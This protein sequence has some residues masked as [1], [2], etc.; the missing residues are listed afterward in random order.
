MITI[1]LPNVNSIDAETYKKITDNLNLNS[2]TYS[3]CLKHTFVRHGYYVRTLKFRN[4]SVKLRILRV[5]CFFCETTHAI[6][7]YF[8]VPYS[9]HSLEIHLKAILFRHIDDFLEWIEWNLSLAEY[10]FYFHYE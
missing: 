5:R 6:L 8:I 7:L 1:C 10:S 2:L 3:K 9:Q 4:S